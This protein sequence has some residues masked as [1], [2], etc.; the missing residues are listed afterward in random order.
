MP[1]KE[2]DYSNTIIY[3]IVCRDLNIKECYVGHT[4]NFTKRKNQHKSSC[5]NEKSKEFNHYVYKFIRQNGNWDNWCMIEIEKYSC[6]DKNEALKRE[7]HWIEKKRATLNKCIPTRTD[8]EYYKD[9]KDEILERTKK[10]RK[11]NVKKISLYQKTTIICNVCNCELTKC[12]ILR[13]NGCL[14]KF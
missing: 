10:Y 1:K 11:E 9:H 2:I 5:T 6:N 4:T 3:K 7:R 13:H 14:P 8:A 12:H